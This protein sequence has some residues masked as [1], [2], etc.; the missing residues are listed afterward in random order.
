MSLIQLLTPIARPATRLM[1]RLSMKGKL[2]VIAL[3]FLTASLI[4]AGMIV[5]SSN[6][7]LAVLEQIEHGEHLIEPAIQMLFEIS[8]GTEAAR[9]RVAG[10]TTAASTEQAHRAAQLA[11][12]GEATEHVGD[13]PQDPRLVKALADLDA[14]VKESAQPQE[15]ANVIVQRDMLAM[16]GVVTFL[17]EGFVSSGLYLDNDVETL[18]LGGIASNQV[19]LLL[20]RISRIRVLSNLVIEGGAVWVE[21]RIDIS[22]ADREIASAFDTLQR[23]IERLEPQGGAVTNAINAVNGS[24]GA[25]REAVQSKL[26]DAEEL[27][28]DAAELRQLGVAAEKSVREL[29]NVV[30][31]MLGERVAER[32]S[33]LRRNRLMVILGIV[34]MLLIAVYLF[35]GFIQSVSQ[36]VSA[37]ADTAKDLA[38]GVF[39]ERVDVDT[40]DEMRTIAD[41]LESVGSALRSFAA[42]QTEMAEKHDAGTI[43][44]M[45]PA[46]QFQGEYQRLVIGVN[47]LVQSHIDTKF[48]AIGLIERY[49]VGDLSKDIALLPG[50]KA[51]VSESVRAVKSNLTAI[52]NEIQRLVN[53]AN[54]GDFTVRGEAD[55]FQFAFREMVDGL[56]QLMRVTDSGLRD[57]GRLAGALAQGDLTDHVTGDYKG[58]F[59]TMKDALN[60]TVESLSGLVG[61]IK[62]STDSINTAAREIAAGNSDLST[63]TEQ[64]AA[65]LE[66]TAASMEE[67]TA[68][69]RQNAEN[70]RSANQLAIGAA[71]VAEKGGQVVDKV[72][73]TMSEIDGSSKKIADIIS[74]IDGI[75]FQ[76]NI[77]A[78]NAA[79]EAARAGEQGRGF[80]VV[81]SEVRS[82]AQ[83]SANAAKEI[84]TLIT[85]S[86]DKVRSG[87]ELVDQAGRT[88]HEVLNSVK[89]VTDIMGEI[90]AASAE[91][92][93][94]I[95]QVSATVTQMDQTT[96]E[97]AAMVEEATAAARSLENQA[98]GLAEAVQRFKL[99]ED[100]VRKA[101]AARIANVKVESKAGDGPDFEA[102]INMHRDWKNRLLDF[103]RRKGEPLVAAEVSKD[104]VCALG[105]WL[106]G[107]GQR[108]AQYEEYAEL[109][110]DHA[111]F[112]RHAGKVISEFEKGHMQVAQSL[113]DHDFS[114]ATAR[115][116]TGIR[117]LRIH[118][119]NDSG[120]PAAVVRKPALV[121]V[122]GTPA[123][124]KLRSTHAA[125]VKADK[126][127]ASVKPVTKPAAS[128]P[129]AVSKPKA[130]AA[131][132]R[133]AVSKGDEMEWTEF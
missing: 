26:L 125:A 75:A 25:L 120:Q 121:K 47:G 93:S 18:S 71:E 87:S 117:K 103:L 5:S 46:D 72:I 129:V 69:V 106:H 80:A 91:Q 100:V 78:L 42:A 37:I 7:Q 82:L 128:K 41:S 64:Q 70:A 88:M 113:L 132:T 110:K 65:S 107:P 61:Q 112:H 10:D 96:Q 79:V 38:H 118:V 114:D 1:D 27:Q 124:A 94:G 131:P 13:L 14:A 59:G 122:V 76:T 44:H 28:M 30:E 84:K 62:G 99:S 23:D 34:A 50:E 95:E 127:A 98:E 6:R 11:A 102:M 109:V 53:A 77:L 56:N 3:S 24:I 12:L 54:A 123:A 2:G 20:D 89:R 92:S 48:N 52:N 51:R 85:D 63:R 9:Q 35:L 68:T 32:V 83:R 60:S 17:N 43:S 31:P 105:E 29:L 15:D 21:D 111:E 57:F 40:R 115:T 66:E 33:D 8:G 73:H 55:R 81:A 119:Q 22:S 4:L 45:I 104:N 133:A 49:G 16:H 101:M 116:L 67:L 90:S 97:N 58:Q 108:F 126:A 36:S 130:V 39:R 86:V 74:V 19:P